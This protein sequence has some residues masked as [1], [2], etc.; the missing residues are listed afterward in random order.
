MV[1]CAYIGVGSNR[2]DRM[3]H[4]QAAVDALDRLDRARLVAVSPWY[5]TEP[6]GAAAPGDFLNGV[7]GL[8]TDLEP[9]ALL[10]ACLAIERKRGR[11]R[12]AREGP[13]TLDLVVLIYGVRV[14]DEP[15]LTVPHPRMA[16]RAFVLVPLADI[17]PR[18]VHPVL[19]CTVAILRSRL[20]DRHAVRLYQSSWSS[21]V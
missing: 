10:E 13:R 3:A 15:G 12:A 18:A 21:A 16:E 5:E 11:A 1:A 9:R 7:V 20:S 2:G 8:E 17:A 4:C 19:G 6:V 14:V